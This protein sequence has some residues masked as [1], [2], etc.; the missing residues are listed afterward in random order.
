M[1]VAARQGGAG[2]GPGLRK[3]NLFLL[4]FYFSP[5]CWDVWEAGWQNKPATLGDQ[6]VLRSTAGTCPE[7][8]PPQRGSRAWGLGPKVSACDSKH[9]QAFTPLALRGAK[10][11]RARAL[12]QSLRFQKG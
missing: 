6:G 12:E 8:P 9:C 11:R 3:K 5:S 4:L 7:G 10:T 2:G 1:P